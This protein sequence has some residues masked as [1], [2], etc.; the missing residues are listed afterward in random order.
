MKMG[1]NQTTIGEIPKDWEVI[2]LG[3]AS[4]GVIG[5][6]AGYAFSSKYFNEKEGIPLIRIRDLGKNST[7]ALYNGPFEDEY[8]VSP[9]EILISMDGEFKA[10]V[11]RGPK[12]LLNQ[13][14]LKVWSK[15]EE[16]LDNLYLYYAIQKPL[17]IIEL[18]VGQTTVKHLSTKHFD[19]ITIPLPPIEEQRRIA[20]VLSG[21][22]DA[23]R[24][25][26]LAI[27]K[28]ERL[29]KGLMQKLLTEGIG[30]KEFKETKIGKIPKTW[31]IVRI[32]HIA[33]VKEGIYGKR[34]EKGIIQ[35]KA[36]SILDNGK[37]NSNAYALITVNH[38]I[39]EYLLRP[40]DILLSN[41]NSANLVG[42][43]AIF[44]GEFS[45]CVFSNLLTRLR[46]HSKDI[47]PE[48]LLYVLMKMWHDGFFK[49]LSTRAVNQALLRKGLVER[50]RV[51]I[52]PVSE[53]QKIAEILSYVNK[54]FDL[55]RMRKE[56]LVRIKKGLMGDL[57]T[58][59]RRVKVAM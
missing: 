5:I 9:G 52:P 17:R 55:E 6:L 42:K 36:D 34:G 35:L 39:D 49:S 38:R 58:G 1:Y 29:K 24:R 45:E 18:Q 20:E 27:A 14:V 46:V 50:L 41:R 23:I 16:Y 28:T 4:P 13:R 21:V 11:W 22:D 31:K 30:H 40:G 25:V 47:I 2:N 8:L 57:L 43:C 48:W 7:E 59:R 12:G 33:S 37:I 32:K 54:K 10:Y 44:R 15:N 19:R 53:Q 56:K 26:D 51:P 3:K